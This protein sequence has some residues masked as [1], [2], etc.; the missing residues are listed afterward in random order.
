VE[1]YPF[2]WFKSLGTPRA[3]EERLDRTLATSMWFTLFPNVVLENLV[4]PA[5]NHYPIVLNGNPVQRPHLHKRTFGYKNDWQLEPGFKDFVTDSWQHRSE[6]ALLTKLS[7]CAEDMAGWSHCHKLKHDIDVSRHQLNNID[8]NSSGE[9]KSQMIELRRKMNRLLAQDDAYWR[10]RAKA[11]W[12]RDCDR[13]T[14]PC[15]RYS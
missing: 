1:G 8:L 15:L 2:T 5:S 14:F 12:Y 10:Q 11:H 13:N 6:I 7:S 9:G 4:A 3:V